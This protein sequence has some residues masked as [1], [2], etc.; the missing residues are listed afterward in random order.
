MR[1]EI[2]NTPTKKKSPKLSK[3]T[4]LQKKEDLDFEEIDFERLKKLEKI[5]MLI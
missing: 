2:T 3:L 4:V 1:P 5:K